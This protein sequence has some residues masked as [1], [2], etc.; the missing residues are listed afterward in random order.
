MRSRVSSRTARKVAISRRSVT[1]SLN[2]AENT[3]VLSTRIRSRSHSIWSA[4]V[5]VSSWISPTTSF[6][7]RR[8]RTWLNVFQSSIRFTPFRGRSRESAGRLE[9]SA[10]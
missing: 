1:P 5:T 9:T 4:T 7:A 8:L 2:S 3:N 10:P 6:S